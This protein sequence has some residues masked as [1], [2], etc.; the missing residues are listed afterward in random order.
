MRLV[1]TI[2]LFLSVQLSCFGQKIFRE[3]YVI[4]NNGDTLNGLVQFEANQGVA[5]M[6]I[7][8]RF[9][10]ANV[11]KYSPDMLKGFGYKNGNYYESFTVMHK[12]VFLECLI[13]GS[14]SV[15]AD[16]VKLFMHS[17]L[18]DLVMLKDKDVFKADGI[19]IA[20]FN[21]YLAQVSKNYDINN[22]QDEIS[23]TIED[24]LPIVKEINNKVTS[25]Y[26]VYNREYNEELF[27]EATMLTG[28]N[29][30]SYGIVSALNFSNSFLISQS[31]YPIGSVP[32]LKFPNSDWSFGLFY[33]YKVSRIFTK[34]S[35]QSELHFQRRNNYFFSTMYR[36]SY[37]TQTY[38]MDL[39]TDITKFSIPL[40]IRYSY[41]IR[42]VEPFVNLGLILNYSITS[43][44]KATLE[45]ESAYNVI[46][47]YGSS[48]FGKK[49]SY[50]SFYAFA[51]IGLK[52]KVL[53]DKYLVIEGR[54]LMGRGSSY[55]ID[56]DNYYTPKVKL[57]QDTPKFQLVLGLGI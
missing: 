41:K 2:V 39:F 48:D 49:V 38:R 57:E 3:G 5:N 52:Y 30:G 35:F 42:I 28:A 27:A 47:T 13:K 51:G 45:A 10:I 25:N 1:I 33:N 31:N 8:K 4:K 15:Y 22:K 11:V 32:N 9:D 7:F 26:I 24:V 14:V 46:Y 43:Y 29:M 6:C 23:A 21:E 54:Y 53:N 44:S 34:L 56:F 16:G 17:L 36:I 50:T 12:H 37:P 40:S 55:S 18:D 20:S 19:R